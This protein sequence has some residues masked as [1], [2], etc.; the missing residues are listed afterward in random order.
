MKNVKILFLSSLFFVTTLSAWDARPSCYKDLERNFFQFKVTSEALALWRV[1]QG[2]WDAIV[3]L[4]Q[5]KGREAESLIE[6]KARR[7]SPNPLQNPFQ[8][9]VAKDLLK[10]TMFQIFER[11]VIESGFFDT[12][13][14]ERMFDYIW[15]SDPRIQSCFPPTPK[16]P[17]NSRASGVT[18]TPASLR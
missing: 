1:P 18:R 13:S 8:P 10:E 11:T 12:V 2:Q 5:F 7:Y 4:A 16:L 15:T 6:R 9:D 17:A 14:I 3:K